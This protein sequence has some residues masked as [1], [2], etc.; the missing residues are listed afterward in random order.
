MSSA[1]CFLHTALRQLQSDFRILAW[2][3]TQFPAQSQEPTVAVKRGLPVTPVFQ[4][5]PSLTPLL[6]AL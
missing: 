6:P 4:C 1:I 3:N 2:P 5:C